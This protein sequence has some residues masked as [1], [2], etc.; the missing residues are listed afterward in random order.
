M[1]VLKMKMSELVKE[2]SERIKV[3]GDAKIVLRNKND[4]DNDI[5]EI[6]DIFFD[7]AN[8]EFIILFK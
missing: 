1:G 6:F 4:Y 7:G 8:D 3:Y 5:K 2:L